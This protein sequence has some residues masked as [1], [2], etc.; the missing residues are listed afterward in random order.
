MP[1]SALRWSARTLVPND[2]MSWA[3]IS[4]LLLSTQTAALPQ[5]LAMRGALHL[6]WALV[7]GWGV[8]LLTQRWRAPLRRPLVA[9]A[10]LWTLVPGAVSPAYWLGLAFQTPS[11]MTM[12]VCGAGLWRGLSGSAVARQV[13][14]TEVKLALDLWSGIG[15]ALGWL[16]LLD[17]L[18]L[19]PWSF[20]AFG[21]GSIATFIVAIL[22]ALTWAT[23]LFDAKS[24]NWKAATLP[25]AALALFVL[26]RLPSG[27]LW[28]ALIDPGLWLVLQG[29]WLI[30]GLRWLRGRRRVAATT[31]A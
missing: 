18:A 24:Q 11:L 9:L 26:T 17:T 20:H 13:P 6:G 25:G 7:L 28:D 4:E 2:A 27:N 15:I 22:I 3:A 29:I 8:M 5:P 12:L 19:L 14:D 21:F 23:V 10:V 16:L 30:R 1:G 31:R